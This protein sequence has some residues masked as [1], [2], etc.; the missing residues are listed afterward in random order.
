LSNYR[1]TPL[2]LSLL[3]ILAACIVV[4]VVASHTIQILAW[5]LAIAILGVLVGGGRVA[6][7]AATSTMYVR[8]KTITVADADVLDE[9]P[10]DETAWA[11]E[12]E[13]RER[14]ETQGTSTVL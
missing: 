5:L 8:G 7:R 13:R 1:V 12:R 11:K 3:V 14:D 10:A 2:A 6:P 4:G 9:A